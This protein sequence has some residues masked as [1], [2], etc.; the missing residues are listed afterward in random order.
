MITNRTTQRGTAT[1]PLP[2][3][4]R[5]G[6]TICILGFAALA[7]LSAGCSPRRPVLYPNAAYQRNGDVVAQR[8]IDECLQLAKTAGVGGSRA[9]AVAGTTAKSAAVGAAA[10][11]AAGAVRGHAGRGA[12]TGAAGAA[13]GGLMH[14]LF[15]SRDLDPV[16]RGFVAECLAERG[17]RIIGWK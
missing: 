6:T 3:S 7:T 11:A 16:E 14:G 13:A 10:G 1:E 8:D 17:Y 4:E 12:A 9:T 15:R 2:T 5:T